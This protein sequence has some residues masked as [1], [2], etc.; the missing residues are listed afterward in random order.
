MVVRIGFKKTISI[1]GIMIATG[2]S[3]AVIFPTLLISI[4]GFLIVGFGVSAVVPLVYS[5]AG[6]SKIVSPGMAL[7][8]VS[9]IGF[10]GFLIG[11]PLI[12]IVAGLFSLRISFLIISVIG[13]AVVLMVRGKNNSPE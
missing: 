6:R 8:A 9:S 4:I 2:L 1:S 3:L 13:I 11:P 10:L 7:A 5:E 12:G